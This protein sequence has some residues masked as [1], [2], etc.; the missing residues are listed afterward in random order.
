MVTFFLHTISLEQT[1]FENMDYCLFLSVPHPYHM[2]SPEEHQQRAAVS[3]AP[4]LLFFPVEVLK[5]F[6]FLPSP[7]I[8]LRLMGALDP[9]ISAAL[10]ATEG[11][12]STIGGCTGCSD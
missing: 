3:P 6:L 8:S 10:Q 9:S 11:W 2:H 12:D 4:L 5:S 7:S 1:V